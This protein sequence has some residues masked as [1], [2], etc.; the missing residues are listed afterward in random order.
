MVMASA[1]LPGHTLQPS[2]SERHLLGE[3][4]PCANQIIWVGHRPRMRQ[5]TT[6]RRRA[7]QPPRFD[8][9]EDDMP[10]APSAGKCQRTERQPR[11]A[12]IGFSHQR[13]Q[14]GTRDPPPLL[15]RPP[16]VAGTPA[17]SSRAPPPAASPAPPPVSS[18]PPPLPPAP[19]PPPVA[20]IPAPPAPPVGTLST[21]IGLRFVPDPGEI[22]LKKA[23]LKH[24][25]AANR[26]AGHS[27]TAKAELAR[28]PAKHPLK[29]ICLSVASDTVLGAECRCSAGIS[30]SGQHERVQRM[31]FHTGEVLPALSFVQPVFLAT[32]TR[33][34]SG[35]TLTLIRA[36]LMFTDG[37]MLKKGRSERTG[38]N[39]GLFSLD[40]SSVLRQ[41]RS[42]S[43]TQCPR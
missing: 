33:G 13:S 37:W 38:S 40:R 39:A 28:N 23:A 24:R 42:A 10:P 9:S 43:C 36:D 32:S 15:K 25:Q 19:P 8:D 14:R 7:L 4:A 5:R 31:A 16:A 17:R 34:M 22:L 27:I 12:I 30:S 20:V 18:G 21:G 6:P 1:A 29:Q 35:Y 26:L 11:A 2:Q 3:P 41:P